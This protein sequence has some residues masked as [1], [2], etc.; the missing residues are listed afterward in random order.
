MARI[1][2]EDLNR[3]RGQG[4]FKALLAVVQERPHLTPVLTRDNNI[5]NAQRSA[6]DQ[7]LL[8]PRS[9]LSTLAST[10]PPEASASGL[11]CNSSSSAC[12]RMASSS[13][14]IP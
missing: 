9:A 8:P 7:S 3:L 13:S 14:L 6:L 5:A 1:K 11:A 2:A 10:T 12:K 4:G